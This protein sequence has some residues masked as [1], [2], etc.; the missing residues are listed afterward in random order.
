[1][2]K[3][4]PLEDTIND[5]VWYKKN[6][7]KDLCKECGAYFIICPNYLKTDLYKK[8]KSECSRYV[9]GDM[10]GDFENA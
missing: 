6:E 7:K 9:L 5:C 1:M 10:I 8:P 4:N 3:Y 2:E